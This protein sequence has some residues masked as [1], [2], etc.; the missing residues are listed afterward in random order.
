MILVDYSLYFDLVRD[1]YESFV[2]YQF[3]CLLI[4]YFHSE[5]GKLD[6]E[7]ANSSVIPL[8]TDDESGDMATTTSTT[9]TDGSVELDDFPPHV[10]SVKKS[11]KDQNIDILRTTGDYLERYIQPREHQCP[12][13][14]CPLIVPNEEFL[15][16]VKRF[17]VQYIIIKPLMTLIA[18]LLHIGGLYHNGS[19]SPYHGYMWVA[20]IVNFSAFLALYWL[21]AFFESIRKVIASHNPISK[22]LAIKLLIFFIFWQSVAISFIYYFNVIP[23]VP[24]LSSHESAGI[25]NNFIISFEIVVLSLFHIRIFPFDEF[26]N[27]DDKAKDARLKRTVVRSMKAIHKVLNPTDII[28][29]TQ[30]VFTITPGEVCDEKND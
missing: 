7:E 23:S 16:K 29:D 24:H 27:S 20:L 3:L 8:T 4:H 30:T 21:F 19:F 26:K 22:F 18:V 1:S 6:E 14:C 25:L 15:I 17:V 12:F 11:R 28:I 10:V 9:S 13:C 5:C 2:L